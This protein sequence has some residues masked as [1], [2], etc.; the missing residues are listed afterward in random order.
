LDWAEAD[1]APLRAAIDALLQRDRRKLRD[2]VS[3]RVGNVAEFVSGRRSIDPA[4][5]LRECFSATRAIP[6]RDRSGAG[7]RF[8]S[9]ARRRWN[10]TPASSAE[11]ERVT[12][13]TEHAQAVFL[14]VPRADPASPDA[15]LPLAVG[16]EEGR[17]GEIDATAGGT[18]EELTMQLDGAEITA[19]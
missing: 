19:L 14:T 11:R 4:A 3:E 6:L 18:P 13:L 7:P 12:Q 5:P 1:G 2:A 17:D 10:P 8:A 9:P 16:A 15:W